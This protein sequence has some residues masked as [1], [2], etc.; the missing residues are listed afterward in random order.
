MSW[1]RSP[2]SRDTL[3]ALNRRSDLL[4]FLQTAGFLAVLAGTGGVAVWS[5]GR[6]SWPAVVLLFLVHG[7]CSS[8][9]FHDSARRIAGQCV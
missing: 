3:I 5:V 1:Y 9:G 7:T 4:G 8:N 6:L 2:L